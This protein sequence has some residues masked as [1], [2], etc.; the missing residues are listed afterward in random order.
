MGVLLVVDKKIVIKRGFLFGPY[1]PIY[2]L[3][4]FLMAFLLSGIENVA[5]LFVL[6]LFLAGSLEYFTSYLMEK[7]Y[8]YRWWDYSYAKYHINGRVT[9]SILIAFGID[10]ILVVK[11]INPFFTNMIS[12]LP[13]N[14]MFL[15]SAIL[16]IIFLVD[17]LFSLF[18]S[19]KIKDDV[20]KV[21][22]KDSTEIIKNKAKIYLNENIIRIFSK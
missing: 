7:I 15:T 5:L 12:S 19:F 9:L 6:G 4:M 22:S 17:L 10:S 20:R 18:I 14:I 13:I 2:G 21:A 11:Y 3:G 8:G 1:I 16:M